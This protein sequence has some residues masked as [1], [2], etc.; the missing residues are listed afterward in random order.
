VC[1]CV[2]VCVCV[3]IDCAEKRAEKTGTTAI[4]IKY[5]LC[6]EERGKDRHRNDDHVEDVPHVQEEAPPQ[7]G[8]HVPQQFLIQPDTDSDSAKQR[9]RG[10]HTRSHTRKPLK[11]HM[12]AP[13]KP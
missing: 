10:K 9:E 3:D 4:I 7:I 1:V 13:Q 12:Q 6:R 2:C 8:T 11:R 5:L